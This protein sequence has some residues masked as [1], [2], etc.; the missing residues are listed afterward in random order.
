LPPFGPKTCNVH[1]SMQ[2][3][4]FFEGGMPNKS[5][6]EGVREVLVRRE[7]AMLVFVKRLTD[8]HM[9]ARAFSPY[10][11]DRRLYNKVR[12]R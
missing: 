7:G 6:G 12:Y 5:K 9:P 4:L 3:T 2:I 1:I 10:Y 8:L 11:I